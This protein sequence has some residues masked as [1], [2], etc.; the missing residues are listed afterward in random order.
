MLIIYEH[1]FKDS[2]MS[3][4]LAILSLSTPLALFCMEISNIS[5]LGGTKKIY[6]VYIDMYSRRFHLLN[7]KGIRSPFNLS[8]K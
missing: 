6:T 2:L 1:I 3:M 5:P 7:L 4:Q 8:L